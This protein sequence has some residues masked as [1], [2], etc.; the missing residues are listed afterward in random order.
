MQN[1][2][3]PNLIKLHEVYEGENTFYMILEYLEGKSL[4]EFI[5]K[6]HEDR[7]PI[8]KVQSIMKVRFFPLFLTLK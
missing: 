6:S 4:S 3:L 5:N 1:L 2:D 8:D 7:I